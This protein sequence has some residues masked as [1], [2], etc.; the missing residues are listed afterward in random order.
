MSSS[1]IRLKLSDTAVDAFYSMF[2]G[3]ANLSVTVNELLFLLIEE[4]EI[5]DCTEP[6]ETIQRIKEKLA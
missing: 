6:E 2:G 1:T 5:E 3:E 4:A